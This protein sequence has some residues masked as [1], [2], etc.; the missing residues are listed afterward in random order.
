MLAVLRVLLAEGDPDPICEAEGRE[1]AVGAVNGRDPIYEAEG[2]EIAVGAVSAEDGPA[3]TV[4]E[5]P[6]DGH[7]ADAA[8][9]ARVTRVA[10]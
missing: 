4:V 1:I 8:A 3:A 7:A 6:W 5:F 10:E 2:W 9:K